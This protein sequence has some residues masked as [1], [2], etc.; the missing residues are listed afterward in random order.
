MIVISD[1]TPIISLTK[2]ESL[3]ILENL[4]KNIILP[5]TVYDELIVNADSHKEINIIKNCTFLKILH[6]KENPSVLLLQKQL[7]LGLGESEVIVL[8]NNINA[9]LIIIDEQKARKAARD[10]GLNVTGTLGILI[11]ARKRG[12]VGKLKPLLDKLI[13]NNIKINR[14]LYMEILSS[15]KE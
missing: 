4:Y 5:K 13:D 11:N 12:L 10:M 1:T 7:K 6:V 9:D 15:V 2:I 3:G 8:A 14:N